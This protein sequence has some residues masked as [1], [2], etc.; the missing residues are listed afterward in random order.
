MSDEHRRY[1]KRCV[2]SKDFEREPE[3][4]SFDDNY[5]YGDVDYE[6]DNE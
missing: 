2:N 4:Y 3:Y 5:F 6:E 1:N